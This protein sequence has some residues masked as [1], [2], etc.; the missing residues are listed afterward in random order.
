[1]FPQSYS[2]LIYPSA[3][4]SR[5]TCHALAEI[6]LG[7]HFDPPPH[8]M[9]NYDFTCRSKRVKECTVSYIFKLCNRYI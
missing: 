9:K 1:M 4:G 6:S 5:K 8:Q 2:N 3:S 7:A